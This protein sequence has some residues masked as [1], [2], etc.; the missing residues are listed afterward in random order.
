MVVSLV[1]V[2]L[3]CAAPVHAATADPAEIAPGVIA[4]S[5]SVT[6]PGLAGTRAITAVNAAKFMQSWLGYSIYGHPVIATPPTS[7]PVYRVSIR[8][9]WEGQDGPL[10]VL[11]ATQNGHAWVT[12]PAPQSLGW[13]F[14]TKPSWIKAQDL[15]ITAFNDAV[16]T[17]PS[18]SP[19]TTARRHPSSGGGTSAWVWLA[20]AAAVVVV[21]GL[22][23]AAL[24]RIRR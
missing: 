10:V 12:M 7:A 1:V 21:A 15:T 11:Y 16:G 8:Q 22:G 2:S 4:L 19:S 6:G 17:L 18:S 5:A 24:R 14:V 13:A 20:A 3:F 9:R 23:L